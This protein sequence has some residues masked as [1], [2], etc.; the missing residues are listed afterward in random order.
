MNGPRDFDMTV[1]P[2]AVVPSTPSRQLPKSYWI[3]TVERL[4]LLKPTE[5]LCIESGTNGASIRSSLHNA[6]A[7]RGYR[8]CFV[9]RGGKCYVW[10]RG[11]REQYRK[12]PPRQ[13]ITCDV[14]GRQVERPPM[15]GSR[16]VRCAG[17][18]RLK[19][20]CQNIA[21][22]ARVNGISIEEAKARSPRWAQEVARG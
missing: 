18:R 11:T 22:L 13:P 4:R 7:Q 20:L 2:R 10:L 8:I 21:R 6:A 19:S 12:H 9:D 14:C 5:A 1:V 3:A 16:Q 15:G 17:S